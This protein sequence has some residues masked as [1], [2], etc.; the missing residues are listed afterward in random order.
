M[1]GSERILFDKTIREAV[2]K[3]QKTQTCRKWSNAKIERVRIMMND[4]VLLRGQ[5]NYAF[6]TLLFWVEVTAMRVGTVRN[7]V[8]EEVAAH[9]G[10]KK[11]SKEEYIEKYCNS[12]LTL[13]IVHLT[14]RVY[15]V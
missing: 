11:Y 3:R 12:D 6:Q 4:N 1:H 5:T 2:R 14:F 13:K 15:D 7:I 10:N 9:C 8:T